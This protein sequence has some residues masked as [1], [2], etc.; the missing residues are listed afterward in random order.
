VTSPEVRLRILIVHYRY[1]VSSGPERYLFNVKR[2]L[3]ERGHE[4][5]VFSVAYRQNEDSEWSSYFV[6][7]IAGDDEVFLEDHTWTPR[8]AIRALGRTFYSPEVHRALSRLLRDTKPDVA[9]VLLYLRKMSPAVLAALRQAHVPT[10]Q[11]LSDYHMVCPAN[12]LTRDGVHCEECVGR[13]LPLPSVRHGCVRGS[14]LL[15]GIDLLAMA[16]CRAAGFFDAV[17][18][19]VAPTALMADAMVRGGWP[20]AMVKVISTP[21]ALPMLGEDSKRDVVLYLGRVDRMKG[22]FT[23][24]DA[25]SIL[26]RA[27][28]DEVPALTLVGDVTSRLGAE[29][30]SRVAELDLQDRVVF[31]GLQDLSGVQYWLSRAIVSV[32]PSLGPENLPNTMLESLAAGVPVIAS[33]QPTLR[34]ALAGFDAGTLVPPG[35]SVALARAMAEVVSDPQRARAAGRAARLLAAERF[36]EETHVSALTALFQEVVSTRRAASESL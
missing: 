5:V 22:V 2:L 14:R 36:S 26:V 21:V 17:D 6:P 29:L 1:F 31:A 28:G 34:E 24:V 16:Y 8:S 25:Y 18:A 11:R 10:V 19:F 23:L 20:Q 12:V 3:E 4:V 35:D 15:S 13:K 27:D 33:D 7:P 9:L 30:R 32:V